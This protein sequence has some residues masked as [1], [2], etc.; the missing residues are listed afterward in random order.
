VTRSRRTHAKG[1]EPGAK[2]GLAT[3]SWGDPVVDPTANVIALT[4]AANRRQDDL[5]MAERE[6][7]EAKLA[8]VSEVLRIKDNCA[9]EISDLRAKHQNEIGTLESGRLNA[10]RQVDVLAV[11]TAAERAQAA[12]Q[13]LATVT[14][15]NADNLR[16][17]LNTTATTIAAQLSTLVGTINERIAALEK[18]SYEGVGKQ[19]ITD[20]A[21]TELIQ[22]V[23]A[24]RE[25]RS[26]TTGHGEGATARRG[27]VAGGSGLLVALVGM[28]VAVL[29]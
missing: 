12:I 28:A 3:D 8:H 16:N 2:P 23:K 15:T 24:L 11:S 20:P 17:A 9:R 6:L 10:I 22:E 18:S 26:T 7:T 29:K 1:P 25:A 4:T 5:R 13:A 19:K 27:Y 14:A 21:M